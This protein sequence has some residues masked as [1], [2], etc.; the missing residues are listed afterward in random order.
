MATDKI[1]HPHESDNHKILEALAFLSARCD[2]AEAKDGMGFNKPD[3]YLGHSLAHRDFLTEEETAQALLML[4]KYA[5]QL[6]EAKITLP[7]HFQATAEAREADDRRGKIAYDAG[8]DLL[9][10]TF[11]YLPRHVG[12]IKKIPKSRFSGNGE[13][14]WTAPLSSGKALLEAFP[15]FEVS[16]EAKQ[17]IEAWLPSPYVGR[18]DLEQDCLSVYFDYDPA[19][20]AL[21]KTIKGAKF[22]SEPP[23][24]E[25][26]LDQ[27]AAAVE[28]LKGFGI[29]KGI[30]ERI[31][32]VRLAAELQL[33]KESALVDKLSKAV[34]FSLPSGRILYK[35]QKEGVKFLLEN[36]RAILAD[37][38]GL[39]KTLVALVAAKAFNLPIIVI[40]PASLQINWQREAELAGAKIVTLSWAKIPKPPDCD[41]VLIADEAHYAQSTK[42]ART[43]ALLR[44]ADSPHCMG[45]FLLTGTPLKNGRPVNLFPLLKAVRHSLAENKSAYEKY[46]CAAHPTRFTKWDTSGAAHLDELHKNTRDV[47]LR[48]TKSQ[49]LDL[50]EKTRVVREVELSDKAAAEYEAAFKKLRAEY[51]QRIEEGKITTEA[52]AIVLLTHL[53]Q[54]GSQAKAETAIELA[55]EV[56]EQGNSVVLFVAFVVSGQAIADALGV[57][58]FAGNLNS[59]ERQTI[60]D[61]FQDRKT[62]AFVGTLQAGGIGITLHAAQT[63]I[64]VDRPYTPGD[65]IQ[66]EDRLH[67]IGQQS[68]VTAI[69]LQHGEVDKEI[70]AILEEK[71]TRIGLILEGKRKSLKGANV[72]VTDVAQEILHGVFD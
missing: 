15:R 12:T 70:D 14:F 71:E 64:L 11:P 59:K 31:E 61:D 50:P 16:Q 72:S 42:A 1:P 36:R 56:M 66:S 37:D 30:H 24:W 23:H 20:V 49:C 26:P 22:D 47:M 3:A 6:S 9:K 51:Y 41:Y 68:A 4:R 60:V 62:R 13:K 19:L 34:N 39:G 57:K 8:T 54:A 65:A 5:A 27:A 10:V 29:G 48:R 53:R 44:L 33:A 2:G 35:H 58:L 28:T 55:Q 67:R 17:K 45:I 69:W 18:V 32:A 43:K 63:V 21:V 52:D 25:I 38:M 7:E 46:Y 40:C